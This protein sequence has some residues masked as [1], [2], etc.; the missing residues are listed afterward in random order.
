M[1]IALGIVVL[2]AV[3]IAM[4]YN[5]L[6][7]LKMFLQEAFSG[8]DVQLK[9]R[10]DLIPNIVE[11]VKGYAQ[12]EQKTLEDI[13]KLRTQLVS[14]PSDTQRESMENQLSRGLKTIFALAENYPDLKANQGFLSLQ[15]SLSEIEDQ[16]QMARRYYNG[17]VRNYNVMVQSFPANTIASLFNF[18]PA[19]FF[20]I[21]YATERQVPDAKFI[22]G[23]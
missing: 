9:R 13:A 17:T 11:T 23:T 16:L 12:H 14:A 19:K 6:I 10:Y 1:F 18:Q 15:N 5:R 7:Q 2:I 21:E 8:I 4:I 20:E 22:K 3:V